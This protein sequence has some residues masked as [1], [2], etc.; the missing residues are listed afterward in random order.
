MIPIAGELSIKKSVVPF[1]PEL[2]E[3]IRLFGAVRALEKDENHDTRKDQSWA[4]ASKPRD[5]KVKILTLGLE[6]WK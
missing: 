1:C 2:F 6:L 3:W 4:D 5:F